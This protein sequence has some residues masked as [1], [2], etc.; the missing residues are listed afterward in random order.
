MQNIL[1][2]IVKEPVLHG[3]W[4][5]TL[6]YLE[7]VG[8]RKISACEDSNSVNLI[9]LKHAAEEHRH[10]FYLKKQISKAVADGF[11][12]YADEWLLAPSQTRRYLNLLDLHTSRYLRNELQLAG[13]NLIDIAYLYV[14]YAIEVRADYLYPV[15]QE[16]LTN[17][18]SKVMVK[19]II[20]EEEG[21]LEEMIEQL[22]AFSPDWEVHAK[23]ILEIEDRLYNQWINQVA[24]E[25]NRG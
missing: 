9:Q 21:H 18:K 23:K 15:Y 12:T 16:V 4:L 5:N 13:R 1:N 11:T 14:T 20:V 19:S 3:K 2:Q 24:T 6:S 17:H 10:A 8:A 22:E 25:I 7:N